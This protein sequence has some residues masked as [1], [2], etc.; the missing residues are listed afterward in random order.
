LGRSL[1]R[2]RGLDGYCVVAVQE[3]HKRKGTK[4][5]DDGL[6]WVEYPAEVLIERHLS[7]LYLTQKVVKYYMM[8]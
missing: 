6:E 3:T 4:A 5:L 8:L 2:V 1:M 7:T